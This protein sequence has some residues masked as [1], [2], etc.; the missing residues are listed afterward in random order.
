[1]LK[2]KNTR[3][4]NYA[5]P[6]VDGMLDIV[7]FLAD[8]N[9]KYGVTEMSRELKLSTNLVFRIMKRLTERGYV[10]TYPGGRYQLDTRF[11]TLGLKLHSRFDLRH[12]ARPF[13]EKLCQATGETVQLQAPDGNRMLALEVI[14]PDN[15]YYL[16]VVAGSRVY[17]HP[18]AFGKCVMAYMNETELNRITEAG[19]VECTPNTITSPAE[20]KKELQTVR[21]TGLAYDRNEYLMGVYCIGAPVFDAGGNAVAGTGIT[22]LSSRFNRGNIN[23]FRKAVRQCAA[24]ISKAIGHTEN[25]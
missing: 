4:Q 7:E 18:N 12:Q 19:L 15:D 25:K 23:I 20:L 9:E 8:H 11:Y 14:T 6:A 1:M 5:V 3:D 2:Q 13:L 21:K 24:E 16:Q 22:G 10:R 17:Y